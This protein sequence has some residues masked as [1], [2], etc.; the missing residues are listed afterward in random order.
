MGNAVNLLDEISRASRCGNWQRTVG[1]AVILL[2]LRETVLRA[3]S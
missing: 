2:W 1:K 3:T